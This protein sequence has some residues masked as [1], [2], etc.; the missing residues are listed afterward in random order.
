M[1]VKRII[2][3]ATLTNPIYNGIWRIMH[4]KQMQFNIR[5]YRL[6]NFSYGML[7]IIAIETI[8]ANMSAMYMLNNPLM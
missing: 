1:E 6:L 3:P 2:N 7:H 5:R 8:I 4:N